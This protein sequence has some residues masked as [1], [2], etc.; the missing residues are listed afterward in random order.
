MDVRGFGSGRGQQ[1]DPSVLDPKVLDKELKLE[2]KQKEEIEQIFREYEV[3]VAELR[4]KSRD[5][6]AEREKERLEQDLKIARQARDTQRAAEILAKLR[7][8]RTD[9][10]DEE[11]EMREQLIEEIEKVLDEGRKVQ[12][13]RL[14]R[15][16]AAGGPPPPLDD[17]KV[18]F[19]CVEQVKVQPYQ[20]DQL[21]MIKR[22]A[23]E[24]IERRTR[25]GITLPPEEEKMFRKRLLDE[26]LA[27]LDDE[28]EKQLRA[29]HAQMAGPGGGGGSI[30]LKD[31]RQLYFAIMQLNNTKDRLDPQ[32]TTEMNRLRSEYYQQLRNVPRDDQEARHRLEE[33]LCQ[34]ILALLKPEQR[35]A[36]ENMETPAGRFMRRREG[37]G[38]PTESGVRSGFQG[39][40]RDADRDRGMAPGDRMRSGDERRSEPSDW[41]R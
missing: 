31:P 27:V 37:Y 20:K 36:I 39:G 5:G 3:A 23:E 19:Q 13:H 8:F 24:E 6:Q 9:V 22:R 41:G 17:P 26:V 2:W 21:D 15:P 30:D 11:R 12:F 18:L 1:I 40:I 32:Q 38:T 29:V 35:A 33:Q 14:L 28:Q 25:S 16:G 34:Q 10:S 4:R 7:E